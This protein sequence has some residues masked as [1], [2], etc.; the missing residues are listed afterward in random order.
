M[1]DIVED[2]YTSDVYKLSLYPHCFYFDDNGNLRTF[3]FYACTTK[4]DCLIEINKIKGMLGQGSVA[5]FA[6]A[7]DNAVIDFSVFFK[8]SLDQYIKWPADPLKQLYNKLY[9]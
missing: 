9:G 4:D 7:T 6:E 3:D 8:R 5:R 1:I 2:I